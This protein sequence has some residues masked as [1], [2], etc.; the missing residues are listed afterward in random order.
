MSDA[1]AVDSPV[2]SPID[3][4]GDGRHNVLR[5]PPR[6]E[7]RLLLDEAVRIK[8]DRGRWPTYQWLEKHLHRNEVDID[9]VLAG[10]PRIDSY[11]WCR[12]TN[13]GIGPSPAGP[14]SLTVAGLA[15]H[16]GKSGTV[17]LFLM[18]LAE[19]GRMRLDLVDDPVEARELVV[20]D[21]DLE[22]R[23]GSVRS[24]AAV[25]EPLR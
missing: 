11:G 21:A 2:P 8:D 24:L 1:V 9:H 19:L 13:D 16:G 23:L 6:P 20:R 10:L 4:V 5:R 22:N 25:R 14:V 18:V 17:D 12:W 7:E 15:A 3:G